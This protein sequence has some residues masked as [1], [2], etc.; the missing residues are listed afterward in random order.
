[1]EL[2][3]LA[4][5]GERLI[6]FASSKKEKAVHEVKEWQ[7]VYLKHIKHLNETNDKK[8]S[9]QKEHYEQVLAYIESEKKKN[10][11]NGSELDYHRETLEYYYR[12]S[13]ELNQE[14]MDLK[15]KIIVFNWT[16]NRMQ[17]EVNV[18]QDELN[19]LKSKHGYEPLK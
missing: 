1:M 4:W 9:E 18:L 13:I 8:L 3:W 12:K 5:I 2:S 6:K 16:I 19:T 15:E 11:E 17:V 10:P 7:D 14:T